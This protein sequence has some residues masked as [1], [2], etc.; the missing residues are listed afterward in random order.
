MDDE[1]FDAVY[2]EAIDHGVVRLVIAQPYR[3]ESPMNAFE[4]I[5]DPA[6]LP[7]EMGLLS[8]TDD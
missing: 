7:T 5:G 8:E 1:R 6:L 4:T 3:P 2:A